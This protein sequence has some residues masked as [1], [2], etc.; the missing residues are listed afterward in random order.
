MTKNINHVTATLAAALLLL[1]VGPREASAQGD[2]R[3]L[4]MGPGDEAPAEMLYAY[5]RGEAQTYFEAR[6]QAIQALETPADVRQRVQRL[7]KQFVEAL[8]GFPERTPLNPQVVGTLQREGYS[9]ERVRYESR[10]HH[11]VTAALYLPEGEPPSPGVLYPLGHKAAGKAAED[12]QRAAIFMAKNGLAVLAYD[13]IGQGERAQLLNE[14]GRP[15]LGQRVY[16]VLSVL[17]YMVK[18]PMTDRERI[19]LVGVGRAGPIALHAAA[20]DERIAHLTMRRSL[21][22]WTDVVETPA[23]IGQLANAVPGALEVYDLPELAATLAPRPVTVER[24]VDATGQ[25]VSEAAIEEAYAPARAAYRAR[26]A[27]EALVFSQQN[28]ET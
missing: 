22:S 23:S 2:L 7:R 15:L 26:Q 25:K 10:P 21:L 9:V 3:V 8:G 13:P 14:A 18:D 16:D 17:E 19:A 5:L 27:E 6:Q 24:G 20:L 11:H 4:N 12:Y 28:G 1:C